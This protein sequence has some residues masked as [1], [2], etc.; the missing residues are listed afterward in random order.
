MGSSEE[1]R[2]FHPDESLMSQQTATP[3]RRS[4]WHMLVYGVNKTSAV[5]LAKAEEIYMKLHGTSI[6]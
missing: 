3:A 1:L 2:K 5:V 6:G 4:W